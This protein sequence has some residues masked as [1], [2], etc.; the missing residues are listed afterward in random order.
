MGGV[1]SK[2]TKK[3]FLLSA[4]LTIGIS[5]HV[6]EDNAYAN[7]DDLNVYQL[8]PIV[9]SAEKREENVQDVPI[10]MDV[11]SSQKIEDAGIRT[12][13]DATRK[14]PNIS[15]SSWGNRSNSQF[16][17]RGIGAIENTPALGF[18]MDDVGYLDAR[19]FNSPLFEIERIEFLRG[20]QGT[21][22]GRNT[23]GG[24]INVVT[25]KPDNELHYGFEA[26]Y[27]NENTYNS[28]IYMRAPLIND[29]LFLGLALNV[30]GSDGFYENIYYNDNADE[31]RGINGRGQLRYTPT[32]ELDILFSFDAEH[33]NDD[34]YPITVVNGVNTATLQSMG[35]GYYPNTQDNSYEINQ[36]FVNSS[37]RDSYGGSLRIAY[38]A[39]AF[40]ITSITAARSV[41]TEIDNDQDFGPYDMFVYREDYKTEY[42]TQELRFAS[43]DDN[44][45]PF[46]WLGGVFFSTQSV[47]RTGSQT[48]GSVYSYYGLDGTSPLENS[49]SRMNTYAVF[50]S[51]T[52]TFFDKLDVTLGL[53][54]EYENGSFD[55]YYQYLDSFYSL[56]TAE[57]SNDLSNSVLLPKLQVAYHWTDDIM[58]YASIARGYRGGGFNY[59]S[60]T[61]AD[62]VYDPEY[63]W[64]YEIGLK[65]S[66][67]DN[68]LLFNTA[69]FY[70][71]IRD[72]QVTQLLST[73]SGLRI[74]NAAK[75]RSYG[76][77][78]ETQAILAKG[79]T[80]EGSFGY[81]NTKFK[82]FI[83]QDYVDYTNYT[84]GNIDYSGN[85]TPF[86]PEFNYSLALQ[87][88]FPLI[89][90]F[91]FAGKEDSLLW[92]N[93]IEVDGYGKT[94]YSEDNTLYQDPYALVNLRSTFALNNYALTFWCN[95]IFDKEYYA[96]AFQNSSYGVNLA[97]LGNP[98]SFGVTF[99][100]K[101]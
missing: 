20:P 93:R 30:D 101:F 24:V 52:Y 96:F 27:G 36:N 65:S 58:T 44:T 50:G 23:L 26:T 29:K 70:M 31:S 41:E 99:S 7:Y 78:I 64:T 85:K 82:D 1:M 89:D 48:L 56:N 86:M 46:K 91:K 28:T 83:K 19:A 66:F 74:D 75:S 90:S 15:L 17:V 40:K 72:Q 71:D 73:G 18:Y 67:F 14:I 59:I 12:I 100:A 5:T 39:P 51:G 25:K 16:Y 3:I 49:H 81:T 6:I 37:K 53:R 2:P 54:Y 38:D 80:F 21:L 69:V 22:Y 77:E 62:S 98:L 97:E 92:T 61:K 57:Y 79:L 84:I 95:N 32:E 43:P 33:I 68:R 94:Y 11:L 88:S 13:V 63:N 9:V 8:D 47:D 10:S 55:N 34:A 60:T 4:L 76:F 35:M 42:F 87:Y 45:S